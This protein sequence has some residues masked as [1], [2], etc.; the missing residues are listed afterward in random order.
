MSFS[1]EKSSSLFQLIVCM[2]SSGYLNK[3]ASEAFIEFLVKQCALTD[4]K[5]RPSEGDHASNKKTIPSENP[6]DVLLEKV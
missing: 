2:T 4:S 1:A 5:K 6:A 3:E